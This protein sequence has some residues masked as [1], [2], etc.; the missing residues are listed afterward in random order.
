MWHTAFSFLQGFGVFLQ[1]FP[2]VQVACACLCLLR[3]GKLCFYPS[4]PLIHPPTSKSFFGLL[5]FFIFTKP[6]GSCFCFFLHGL[7]LFSSWPS[8]F[9]LHGLLIFSSWPS[10]FFFM[11]FCFF[12]HGLLIFSSWPSAFFLHGL[13]IFFFMAF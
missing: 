6:R 11:A 13:L 12:L 8:D 3:P 2:Y 1:M 5:T 4:G 7:L 9:F 10:A